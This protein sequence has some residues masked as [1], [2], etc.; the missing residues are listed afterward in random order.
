MACEK[1]LIDAVIS[2]WSQS[3]EY[4]PALDVGP[5]TASEGGN[6]SLKVNSVRGRHPSSVGNL[7]PIQGSPFET[8]T[9]P[10]DATPGSTT[11]LNSLAHGSPP[12]C[13]SP[14]ASLSMRQQ[15]SAASSQGSSPGLTSPALKRND[16]SGMPP[17]MAPTRVRAAS[18]AGFVRSASQLPPFPEGPEGDESED[19]PLDSRQS[20]SLP[21][22]EGSAQIACTPPASEAL[23][24]PPPVPPLRGLVRTLSRLRVRSIQQHME[25]E[26]AMSDC[27]DPGNEEAQ[28]SEADKK[29]LVGDDGLHG[30]QMPEN[31]HHEDGP[32]CISPQGEHRP[33][34]HQRQQVE[35]QQLQQRKNQGE[36]G[37]SRAS[38]IDVVCMHIGTFW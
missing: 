3:A 24:L 5:T 18:S 1:A 9:L 33:Q 30:A 23:R 11:E 4:S 13:G 35:H 32:A 15:D 38:F 28:A 16:S 34:Y 21:P 36:W 10:P 8:F 14:P 2:T 25:G 22:S 17:L 7:G 31:P 29:S 6:S 19:P 26:K 12:L 37:I 20:S 27:Q